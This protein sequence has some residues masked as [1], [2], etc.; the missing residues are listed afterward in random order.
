MNTFMHYLTHI[1]YMDARAH[2]VKP[3][4]AYEVALVTAHM[5][6]ASGFTL[7]GH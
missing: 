1:L 3:A 5:L 4:L 6:I 2:G 7:K